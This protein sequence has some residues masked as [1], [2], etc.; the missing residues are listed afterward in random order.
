[1]KR[2]V[3]VGSGLAHLHVLKTL[4]KKPWPAVDV[5]LVAPHPRQ[6]HTG[7]VPGWMAGHYRLDECTIELA[8]LVRAAGG[9]LIQD[10]ASGVD[11][12]RR[13]LMT[14]KSGNLPYDVLSLATGAEVDVSC[15]AATGARLV[16][17]HPLAHFVVEWEKAVNEFRRG[18]RAR[19]VVVGGSAAGVEL[20]LAARHRLCGELGDAQVR[21]S[22][23]A[24]DGL[25]PG[26]GRRVAARVARVIAERGV[27]VFFERAAGCDDGVCLT[28]GATIPADCV[29]AA[30]GARAASWLSGCFGFSPNGTEFLAVGDGQQSVSHR[31]VFAAG[32]AASRVVMPHARSGVYSVRAGPILAEN[33]RRALAGLPPQSY[34]PAS[35]SLCLL[36]TGPQEAI[37]SWSG[38]AAGG[39]WAWKWKERIDRRFVAPYRQ[40]SASRMEEKHESD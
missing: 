30:T 17:V 24:A 11:A 34:R 14:M 13:L 38:F 28:G 3:L 5:L 7:M 10:F 32:D 19:V 18:G 2:L 25:L 12:G 40:P 35:R 39:R 22:L 15:L 6:I 27:D 33:L 9:R 21:V 31:Q 4:A 29:I 36:A 37:A 20:A 26:H 23:V 8:P 1:M 16:S